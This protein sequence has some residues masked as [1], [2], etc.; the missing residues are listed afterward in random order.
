MDT[1]VDIVGSLPMQLATPAADGSHSML[2]SGAGQASETAL[3]LLRTRPSR[4]KCPRRRRRGSGG[5]V[6]SVAW[7]KCLVNGGREQ[8]THHTTRS[9]R[10]LRG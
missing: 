4:R 2:T 5:D 9:A 10:V 1:M 6:V 8:A 3:H 7:P